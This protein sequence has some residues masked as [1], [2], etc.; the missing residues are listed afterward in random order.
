MTEK[1]I[2]PKL[3]AAL[4]IGVACGLGYYATRRRAA[5][6]F[7]G[8]TVVITGG[9]RG[10]GLVLARR[11]AAEGARLALL[12]RDAATLQKAMDQLNARG[13][14]VMAI[15]CDVREQDQVERAIKQ[16][17]E[18]FGRID[19]LVNNAGTVCVG[20][21]EQMDVDDFR[22]AF[23]IHALGPV[24]TV[25]AVLPYMRAQG[26]GR[27]VNISSIGGKLAVPHMVPYSAS[28]FALTGLSDGLRA[29]LARHR[30]RVTTV[31]P[32]LM[33]TG[34]P[35]NAL[36]KGQH[37]KEYAWFALADS[38]PLI[39]IDANRAA[40]RIVE[41]CRRGT[42]ELIISPQARAAVLF[43]ALFPN[44]TARLM[45]LVNRLLPAPGPIDPKK[46]YTGRESQSRVA[47]SWATRLGDAATRRNNE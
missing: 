10:L 26:E 6:R 36:F 32:G 47:P 37:R 11:L 43:G 14:E 20:P 17:G 7:H 27:I 15:P 42:P 21:L 3:K 19:V 16:V 25:T 41:A 12:A 31:C 5:Y 45:S 23:A 2:D 24:Y 28:K 22:D 34:S 30:I 8:R 35:P 33:R 44:T 9:S 29:E 46:V 40:A 38:A 39:S 1:T 13:A 4:V 18:R